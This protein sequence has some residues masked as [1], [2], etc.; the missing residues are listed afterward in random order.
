MAT[1]RSFDMKIAAIQFDL[2]IFEYMWE[3]NPTLIF[4]S[5]YLILINIL[6]KECKQVILEISRL[7]IKDVSIK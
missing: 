4:L 6:E 2:I 1:I 7:V 3:I 5:V